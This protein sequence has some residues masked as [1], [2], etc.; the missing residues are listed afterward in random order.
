MDGREKGKKLLIDY[1]YPERWGLTKNHPAPVELNELII[2]R[3]EKRTEIN[4]S[5]TQLKLAEVD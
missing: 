4:A 5:S 2:R 1:P 3:V